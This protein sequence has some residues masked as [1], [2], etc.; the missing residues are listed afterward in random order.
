MTGISAPASRTLT[1]IQG[2]F[3]AALK[4]PEFTSILFQTVGMAKEPSE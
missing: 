4:V 2:F 1:R 3:L